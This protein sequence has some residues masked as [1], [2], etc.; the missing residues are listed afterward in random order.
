M[1]GCGGVWLG[2]KGED[3]ELVTLRLFRCFATFAGE[4]DDVELFETNPAA[5]AKA[6]VAFG[7]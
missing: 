4:G 2:A 3:F 5:R 1:E 6:R 7:P